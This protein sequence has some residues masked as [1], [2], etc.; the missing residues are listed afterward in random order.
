MVLDNLCLRNTVY[1]M[2]TCNAVMILILIY[3]ELILIALYFFCNELQFLQTSTN[4]E[5]HLI[6]HNSS[7][8]S[9]WLRQELKESQCVSVP[10]VISCLELS[11][12]WLMSS[13]LIY[14]VEKT[15][16][17]MLCLVSTRIQSKISI[18]DKCK[19]QIHLSTDV[20]FLCQLVCLRKYD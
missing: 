7:L 6:T 5:I 9:F 12:F 17:T 15:E 4:F 16:P 11:I 8:V 10:L 1:F 19:A 3:Q 14:F 2:F 18:I 13:K 20:L